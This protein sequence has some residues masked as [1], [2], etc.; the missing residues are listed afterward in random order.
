MKVNYENLIIRHSSFVLLFAC[1]LL[2][3]ACCFSQD[4]KDKQKEIIAVGAGTGVLTFHGDVGKGSLV[5]AYSDI[6]SAFS[7]SLEKYLNRNFALSFN[8]L[9]GKVARD[10]KS[11]DNLPKL[12]FESP[13]SQIGISGTFLMQGKKEQFVIPFISAGIGFVAFDPHAD[14]LDKYGNPYYYWKDGSIRDLPETS[15]NVFYAQNINRDYT[16]ETRLGKPGEFSHTAMVLPVSCGVKLKLTSRFDANLGFSYH[17]AFTDYIDYVKSGSNDKYLFTYA[18]C[19][20]HIFTLPKAEKEKYSNIDFTVIDNSDSDGDGIPDVDDKCPATPKGVKVDGKGCPIDSDV[21]GVPD[22]LDKEPHSKGGLPVDP[23]GVELTRERLAQ[24]QKTSTLNIDASSRKDVF[25][26]QFNKKPSA[27]FMKE[28]EAMEM[29]K[30]K[31]QD[32]K[33]ANI[34]IPYDLRVADWNKD[35]FI[36]SDEIAK[37]IDAFF[38]GSINFSAEQIHRL[39]DF[40]F[41]Q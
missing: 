33:K 16:Y 34:P 27:A 29:E 41:E 30:R 2:P 22:Y 5:G 9:K 3:A 21:D 23:D 6:R 36:T 18:S 7:L 37:T 13:I 26:A 19:T 15:M 17:F 4:Y 32:A 14:L 28:V 11:S 39:I 20:W 31:I 35:G 25:S 1:C 8:L 38:D 10:E 40:F 24:I 12:N